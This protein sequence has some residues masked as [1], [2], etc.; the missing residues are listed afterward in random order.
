MQESR[1]STSSCNGASEISVQF[2]IDSDSQTTDTETSQSV[3]ISC[4]C[5]LE[6]RIEFSLGD[7]TVLVQPVH[8]A[9]KRLSTHL[10]LQQA[11]AGHHQDVFDRC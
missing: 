10:H 4:C 5:Y 1:T 8:Q 3:C 2:D 6:S 9:T 11:V 7:A